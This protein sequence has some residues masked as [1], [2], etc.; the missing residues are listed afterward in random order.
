[1]HEQNRHKPCPQSAYSPLG[2]Q[3][4]VQWVKP[5]V[6]G[7]HVGVV[8]DFLEAP[9]EV[10]GK[11]RDAATGENKAVSGKVSVVKMREQVSWGQTK[12]RGRAGGAD[13]TGHVQT[14]GQMSPPRPHG[15][16]LCVRFSFCFSLLLEPPNRFIKYHKN[17]Y[18]L[19]Y[20]KA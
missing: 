17:V 13:G 18:A 16:R 5:T 4:S 7:P 10:S 2:N 20:H 14:H 1:M 11:S 8:A 15:G 19:I 3:F 9:G 12:G 6:S